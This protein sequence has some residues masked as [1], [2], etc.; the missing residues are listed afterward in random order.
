MCEDHRNDVFRWTN[1]VIAALEAD[2]SYVPVP[3]GSGG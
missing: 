1:E 3:S 2:P